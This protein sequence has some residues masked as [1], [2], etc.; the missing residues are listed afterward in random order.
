MTFITSPVFPRFIFLFLWSLIFLILLN[1]FFPCFPLSLSFSTLCWVILPFSFL[2]CFFYDTHYFLS[3]HSFPLCIHVQPMLSNRFPY[4]S[5]YTS[6]VC[7]KT[8]ICFHS[9]L[10][11]T[12]TSLFTHAVIPRS[13]L[14]GTLINITYEWQLF[15]TKACTSLRPYLVS[16]LPTSFAPPH[17]TNIAFLLLFHCLLLLHLLRLQLLFLDSQT[18]ELQ[19]T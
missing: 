9:F 1:V 10:I 7:T 4:S 18:L 11:N 5:I 6:S 16:F 2:K 3:S 17:N 15:F 14:R 8:L 19:K 13:Y 12:F